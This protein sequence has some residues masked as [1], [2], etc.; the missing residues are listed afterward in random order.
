MLRPYH[1]HTITCPQCEQPGLHS[2]ADACIQ[3]LRAAVAVE[4]L[5]P[6]PHGQPKPAP[7]P[8]RPVPVRP[9]EIPS[10]PST[11]L[12]INQACALVQVT[13]RCLYVWMKTGK[14]TWE[15][16][17]GGARRIYRASLLRAK[18]AE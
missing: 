9:V 17:P 3:A 5:R 16:T 12:T 1:G 4:P 6:K 10:D 18:R 11:P 14:L 8:V 7:L 15:Y 2:T 13:R